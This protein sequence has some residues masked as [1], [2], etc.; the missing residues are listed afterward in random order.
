MTRGIIGKD[1]TGTL[2]EWGASGASS[3]NSAQTLTKAAPGAGVSHFITQIDIS[4]SA[5]PAAGVLVKLNDG[6]SGTTIWQ[7]IFNVALT[8]TVKFDKPL[9]LSAAN[10]AELVVAAG[11]SGIISYANM[12]GW[13]A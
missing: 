13:D 12:L 9:G 10:A 11:G 3:A 4:F 6:A 2:N 7:G 5:A 1:V 8:T